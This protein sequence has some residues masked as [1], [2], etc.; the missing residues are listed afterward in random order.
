VAAAVEIGTLAVKA[1]DVL[2]WLGDPI[3]ADVER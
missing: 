3:C 1:V 2:G